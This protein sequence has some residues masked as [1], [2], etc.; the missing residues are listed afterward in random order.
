[1]QALAITSIGETAFQSVETPRPGNGDVLLD[2]GCVGLCGSDLNT[3]K[4]MNPLATLPRIP[5]HEIGGTILDVGPD[6]P[7]TFARGTRAVVVPYTACGK[8]SA[9][10][11]G[12]PNACKHNQTLGVQRDGGMADRLVVP[13]TH[14]I[15]NDHLSLRELALVEPLSVGFHAVTRGS[16]ASGDAVVVLGAGMIGLGAILGA[17][18]KGAQVIVV[19]I[20][21]SKRTMLKALGVHDV[22]N[23][24]TENLSDSVANLTGGHGADVVIEAVGLPETFRSAVD[25]ACFSGRIVYVGYAKSE[26]SYNTALFNLKELDI[27]GSRNATRTD[28]EA[29]IAFLEINPNLSDQL[30]SRV[31]SW[32]DAEQA[33]GYWDAN[34]QNTFKVMIDMQD[35]KHA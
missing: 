21:E 32:A 29:V 26:V 33:F 1:M 20:S 12:R 27:M 22:V 5:G 17:L 9:C 13:H 25:L 19:E 30:I 34:R 4:G 14:L 16:V 24:T 8:C 7:S 18:A 23:P 10:K 31:F 28:F 15:L 11:N 3:F 35:Q 6:V 2:V